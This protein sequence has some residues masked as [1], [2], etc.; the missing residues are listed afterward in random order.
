MYQTVVQ[1]ISAVAWPVTILL[2]AWLL[3]SEVRAAVG[4]IQEA[5]LPGGAEL[6]FGTVKA[7][8]SMEEQRISDTDAEGSFSSGPGNVYWLGHDVM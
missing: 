8:T 2:V 5:K 4:R 3:R 6:S 7:D 1:L